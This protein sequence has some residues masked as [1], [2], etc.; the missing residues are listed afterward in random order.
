MVRAAQRVVSDPTRGILAGPDTDRI[1]DRFDG[2]H[3][4][5]QGL[6]DHARAWR[7]VL[8]RDAIVQPAPA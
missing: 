1:T 5:R 3:M 2:C 8:M 6:T 4:G 7:E